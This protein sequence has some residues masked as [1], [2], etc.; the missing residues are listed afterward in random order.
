M[1]IKDYAGYD[2][3]RGIVVVNY[4]VIGGNYTKKNML[5]GVSTNGHNLEKW[6]FWRRS[7]TGENQA[8][9]SSKHIIAIEEKKKKKNRKKKKE[10]KI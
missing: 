4:L 9:L 8:S 10:K 6:K 7:F 3:P 2:G 5:I 1:C